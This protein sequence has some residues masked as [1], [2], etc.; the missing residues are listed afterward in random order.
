MSLSKAH[1]L[2][3]VLVKPRKQWLRPDMTE[4]LLTGPQHKQNIITC[5]NVTFVSSSFFTYRE[6]NNSGGAKAVVPRDEKMKEKKKKKKKKLE[7]LSY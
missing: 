6:T 7:I 2:P 1:V 5:M 3:I 4:K